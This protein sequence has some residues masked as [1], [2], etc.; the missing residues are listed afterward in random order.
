MSV[1]ELAITSYV[2][3]ASLTGFYSTPVFSHL[4]PV[5]HR[6]SVLKIIANCVIIL[7]LSSA[8]PVLTR[9]LGLTRF[10]LVGYFGSFAW[11]G[12]LRVVL[13]YNLLF[14]IA[15]TLTL[16][17]RVTRSLMRDL[18]KKLQENWTKP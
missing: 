3:V 10:D 18:Q 9:M 4:Q 13:S 2:V 12:D 15:M 11:L 1:V 8:M 7:I 16:T 5:L 14:E 17:Q 6:T